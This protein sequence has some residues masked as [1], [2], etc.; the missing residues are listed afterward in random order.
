MTYLVMI[1]CLFCCQ[2]DGRVLQVHALCGERCCAGGLAGA[3][4]YEAL[5]EESLSVVG[6]ETLKRELASVV[7]TG[8]RGCSLHVE[9]YLILS[10]RTEISVLVDHL[11]G[12]EREALS[13]DFQLGLVG[14]ETDMMRSTGRLDGLFANGNVT[15]PGYSRSASC[16]RRNN[17][18]TE[19]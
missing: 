15:A 13:A 14:S 16:H 7:N 9:E 18:S 3:Q 10:I 5:P 11:N 4:D 12:N 17:S 2:F 19:V 6:L 1:L 8:E